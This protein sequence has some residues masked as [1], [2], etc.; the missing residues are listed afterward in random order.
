M[1][2]YIILHDITTQPL[3]RDH[4]FE[5]AQLNFHRDMFSAE[6]SDYVQREF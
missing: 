4:S 2:V 1:C 5:S 6:E 3:S